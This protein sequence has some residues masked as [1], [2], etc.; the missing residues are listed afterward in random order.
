MALKVH[1]LRT[2]RE[3]FPADVVAK[4]ILGCSEDSN[5]PPG[6]ILALPTVQAAVSATARLTST[7]VGTGAASVVEEVDLSSFDTT[8]EHSREENL[9]AMLGSHPWAEED[10]PAINIVN[11][12][13]QNLAHLCAQLGYNRLLLAVIEWGIDIRAKD[14]NGW[15]PLDFARLNKGEEAIDMLEGDWVDTAEY[16]LHPHPND[17]SHNPIVSSSIREMD[18]GC[19]KST[20]LPP[21]PTSKSP[22]LLGADESMTNKSRRTP[23][24]VFR[25]HG[26]SSKGT[27]IPKKDDATP[28]KEN[29]AG[30]AFKDHSSVSTGIELRCHD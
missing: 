17:M 26:S 19:I 8:N 4:R 10:A 7:A 6:S 23:P 11:E 2:W 21:S 3:L 9:L 20:T 15:T 5:R 29:V 13:G 12:R 16:A 27:I 1:G 28:N 30:A 24:V 18:S 22:A 14:V 25:A